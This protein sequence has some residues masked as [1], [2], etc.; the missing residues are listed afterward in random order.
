MRSSSK[1]WSVK[2][3]PRDSAVVT[4]YRRLTGRSRSTATSKPPSYCR[5][6]PARVSETMNRDIVGRRYWT[7]NFVIQAVQNIKIIF[8]SPFGKVGYFDVAVWP[9]APWSLSYLQVPVAAST[10]PALRFII[11]D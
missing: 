8:T 6:Q 2:G 11:L 7:L 5:P 1:T 9:D 4:S 3:E 10:L